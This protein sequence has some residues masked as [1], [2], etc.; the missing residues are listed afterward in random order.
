MCNPTFW[1]ASTGAFRG[2]HEK[3]FAFLYEYPERCALISAIF[4]SFD[5]ELNYGKIVA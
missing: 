1:Q 4:K 2:A 3:E 5:I